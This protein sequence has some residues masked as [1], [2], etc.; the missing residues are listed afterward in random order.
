VR[1]KAAKPKPTE[2][3]LVHMP[4]TAKAEV[5]AI[6][7][8]QANAVAPSEVKPLPK[9][10]SLRPVVVA[11]MPKRNLMTVTNDGDAEVSKPAIVNLRKPEEIKP[12]KK[13][14]IQAFNVDAHA[15]TKPE[16]QALNKPNVPSISKP[17]GRTV[18]RPEPYTGKPEVPII[19]KSDAQALNLPKTQPPPKPEVAEA[20][21]PRQ[22]ADQFD[23][24]E[25]AMNAA[26]NLQKQGKE[27]EA[28]QI[29]ND[30]AGTSGASKRQA[31]KM[32]RRMNNGQE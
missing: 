2:P 31:R 21:P 26:R 1:Q 3:E 6:R 27:E 7:R 22:G 12:A 4:A 18:V 24:R 15:A 8:A 17:E 25:A 23:S 10:V 9:P 14:E 20:E 13:P 11:E 16:A 30:L 28:R 32:L 5:E 19:N 29:L